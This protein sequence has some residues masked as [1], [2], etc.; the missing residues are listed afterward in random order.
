MLRTMIYE[1]GAGVKVKEVAVVCWYEAATK[2]ST[3][4]EL[5]SAVLEPIIKTVDGDSISALSTYPLLS[6]SCKDRVC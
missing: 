5:Q 4:V 2:T 6:R 1:G 3:N